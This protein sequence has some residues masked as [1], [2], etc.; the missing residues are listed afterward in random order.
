MVS[1]YHSQN[2][3][4][5]NLECKQDKH[6]TALRARKVSLSGLLRNG[7]LVR[8]KHDHGHSE[9]SCVKPPLSICTT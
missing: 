6:K 5:F 2:Y 1:L 8:R 3:W 7:P 9:I 4:N